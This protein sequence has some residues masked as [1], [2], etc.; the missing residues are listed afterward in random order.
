MTNSI[1]HLI[2]ATADR[3]ILLAV[4]SGIVAFLTFWTGH[5]TIGFTVVT[6]ALLV[7]LTAATAQYASTGTIPG[8]AI[9]IHTLLV[10]GFAALVAA[11]EYV[12]G[13][14]TTYTFETFVAAALVFVTYLLNEVVGPPA[15]SGTSS[16]G[17]ATGTVPPPP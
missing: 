13:L 3:Y 17:S 4:L 9:P 15:G 10:W 5:T 6:G 7:G 2:G 14:G 1:T 12:I 8:T 16:G 11:L